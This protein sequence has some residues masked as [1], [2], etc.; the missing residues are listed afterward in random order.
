M[1]QAIF[2]TICVLYLKFKFKVF[3]PSYLSSIMT[4]IVVSSANNL[5]EH[6]ISKTMSLINIRNRRGPRIDPCGTPAFIVSRV[7]SL[8]FINYFLFSKWKNSLL[9]NLE[10]TP[11]PQKILISRST[12]WCQTR[13]NALLISKN[14]MRISFPL[15][16]ACEISLDKN[17]NWLIVESP[18]VKTRLMRS[19]KGC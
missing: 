7:D 18:C 3:A 13:S 10:E 15:S 1:S 16:R 17:N 6:S 5:I 8:P 14:T 4:Y 9:S 12:L 11:L 19:Q 2:L